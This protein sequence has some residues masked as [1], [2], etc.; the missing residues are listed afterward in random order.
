MNNID[1]VNHLLVEIGSRSGI[2]LGELNDAGVIGFNYKETLAVALEVAPDEPI[3][4]IYADFGPVSLLSRERFCYKLLVANFL[5][6][7]TAGAS[8]AVNE[9]ERTLVLWKRF[10]LEALDATSLQSILNDFLTTADKWNQR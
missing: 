3:G 9:T 2:S 8:F 4:C 6:R 10:T 5:G 1:L 7:D